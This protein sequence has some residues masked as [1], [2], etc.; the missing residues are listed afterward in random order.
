MRAG[1]LLLARA[2]PLIHP[3]RV[4]PAGKK[5]PATFLKEITML[6][7]VTNAPFSKGCQVVLRSAS[8]SNLF[9]SRFWV[10]LPQSRRS[11]NA[12]VLPG[13]KP[14]VI[15]LNVE[16]VI[17][18][19]A[20]AKKD[21]R[22]VLDEHPPFFGCGVGILSERK[23]WKAVTADRLIRLLN[24]AEEERALFIDV[25]RA[26]ELG[27][28]Y[29]TKDVIDIRS[30][31]S[32]SVFN[33]D[34][35]DDPYKGEPQKGVA[36]NAA[37]GKRFSQ[38]AHDILLGVG[39]LRGYTSPLW[40]A[41]AQMKYLNVELN[42]NAK[43][44]AVPAPSMTGMIVCLS[45]LPPKCQEELLSELKNQRPDAFGHDTFFIYNVN[46]WETTR[47]RVL[48]RN[49]AAVND[50]EY[51]F[52][53]VN[54]KDLRLQKPQYSSVV[55][56]LTGC[57]APLGASALE[58]A[59][60]AVG[61]LVNADRKDDRLVLQGRRFPFFFAEDATCRRYYNADCMAKPYLMMPSVRPIAILK[62]RLLGPRDESVLRA[63]ALK[64]K[65]SSP[66]WVTESAA[67]RM[68]VHI[69]AAHKKRYVLIGAAAADAN[70]DEEVADGFYNIDDFAKPEEI[71]SLFPKASK[72][73]HFMLDTKWRAVLGK[74]RQDYLSSLN[75]DVPLWVSV[76]ECL[77]SGFEPRPGSTLLSFPTSRKRDKTG[78]RLYN[79]Q[80]TT[81]P[82]R[83]IG[84][85]SVYTRPQ[86]L[87]I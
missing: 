8:R 66:I 4:D 16:K 54:L 70:P 61:K 57:K 58:T 76:N 44:Q 53:F 69:A 47:S 19:K 40:I 24:A 38:P 62:G 22:Q 82:V 5:I 20:L 55:I 64:N 56:Q 34:Q 68:G 31:S 13:Q 26:I 12:A 39:I 23:K 32:V 2:I 79:S 81:D 67:E 74:Q 27:L 11:C 78:T 25:N 72:K 84:L 7:A 36:L 63:F 15:H 21:Q 75:R 52:H 60:L 43:K 18:L 50:R 65:L 37:T 14:A 10:T 51:P 48:V 29:S 83:V 71:L 49:M 28:K 17:P 42:V 46:G 80:H 73:V 85:S 33:S 41:E 35:L 77:M 9:S 6:S 1:H 3:V 87:T 45:V 86:G 59:G 30:A